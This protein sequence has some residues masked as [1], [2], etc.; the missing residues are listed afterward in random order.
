MGMSGIQ[1]AELLLKQGREVILY[2]GNKDKDVSTVREK[3][4]GDV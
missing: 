2:D 3:L 4:T 1:A